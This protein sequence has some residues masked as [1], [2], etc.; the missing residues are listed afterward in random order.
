M[1]H[2]SIVK[3]L[4]VIHTDD[5][6]GLVMAYEPGV[7]LIEYVLANNYVQ[8][9]KAKMLFAQLA[10]AVCYMHHSNVVHRDIKLVRQSNDQTMISSS[11][12]V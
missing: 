12:D 6:I 5:R 3:L 2:P 4:D 11:H 7:E 8:E 9:S 10:R 1:D